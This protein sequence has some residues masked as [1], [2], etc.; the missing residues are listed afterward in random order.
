MYIYAYV[1]TK[2][3]ID[4]VSFTY[5]HLYSLLDSLLD[6]SPRARAPPEFPVPVFVPRMPTNARTMNEDVPVMG[7]VGGAAVAGALERNT[8]LMTLDLR[9]N[10]VH[11]DTMERIRSLLSGREVAAGS[12]VVEVVGVKAAVAAPPRGTE[13]G[14]PG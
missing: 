8:T 13:R 4:C 11:G 6:R 5:P 1:H 7:R 12:G 2:T 9:D 10:G 14:A 3:Q